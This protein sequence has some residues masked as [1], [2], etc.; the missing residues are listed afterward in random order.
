[1]GWRAA[2]PR[3]R[4]RFR[5]L[6]PVRLAGEAVNETT[7]TGTMG[8]EALKAY[9]LARLGAGV[10]VEESLVSVVVAKT[11]LVASLGAFIAGACLL[12]WA[13]GAPSAAILALLA[14][15]MGLSTVGFVWGQLRGMLHLGGR[16]LAW[17]GLGSRVAAGAERL[18]A[19]LRWVFG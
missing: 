17:M 4:P 7:P 19:R 11:A 13:F 9:L 1:E 14:L 2:F 8:G 3:R 6:F 12:A 15:Y 5:L 10:P 16:A 18:E